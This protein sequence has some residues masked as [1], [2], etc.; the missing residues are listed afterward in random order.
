MA[1]IIIEAVHAD[2]EPRRWTLSERIVPNDF[3]STHYASQLLERLSWAVGDAQALE[4]QTGDIAAED[5]SAAGA[6]EHPIGRP[7]RA[8]DERSR[9]VADERAVLA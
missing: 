4:A 9:P 1:R 3:H 8:S 7:A 6:A 5:Q 2:G